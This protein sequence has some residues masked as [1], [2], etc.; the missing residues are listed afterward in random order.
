MKQKLIS[1]L[2]ALLAVLMLFSGCA[3]HGKTF[4]EAGREEISINVFQL[5][6][7][8]MKGSARSAVR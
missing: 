4:I 3:A 6:L 7:S 5:Y 1:L 8:R 2:A